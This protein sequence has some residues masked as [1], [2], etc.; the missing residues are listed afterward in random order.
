MKASQV[1][2]PEV[3]PPPTLA[4]ARKCQYWEG[5]ERAI[6]TEIDNLENNHTWEYVDRNTLPK[7]TNILRSK[8]IFDIKR[9]SNG[10]FIKHKLGLHK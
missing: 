10:S 4:I 3:V 9:D 1:P 8:V 5:W 6:K 7:N 2:G